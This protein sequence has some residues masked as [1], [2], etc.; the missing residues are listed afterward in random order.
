MTTIDKIAICGIRSYDPNGLVVIKFFKPLTIILGNNGCGKTTII[1][2]LKYVCTGDV[3]PLSERGRTFVHD[4]NHCGVNVVKAQVKVAFKTRDGKPVIVNSSMQLTQKPRKTEFKTIDGVVRMYDET[5]NEQIA[6]S[7]KCADMKK[8]VP[9]LMGVSRAILDNVIFCHQEEADWPLSEPKKLKEKFDEIFA[10]SRWSKA[11]TAITSYRKIL[12]TRSKDIKTD[13]KVFENNKEIAHKLTIDL[14]ETKVRM[15]QYK[16][17]SKKYSDKIS[18]FK[19]KLKPLQDARN[20]L[21]QFDGKKRVIEN[22]IQHLR[23]QQK[24]AHDR[25]KCEYEETDGELKEFLK[26]HDKQI[27]NKQ[28]ELDNVQ[29]EYTKLKKEVNNRQKKVTELHAKRGKIE[30]IKED[31]KNKK[32]NVLKRIKLLLQRYNI[33]QNKVFNGNNNNNNNNVE[34]LENNPEIMNK[35]I[36]ELQNEEKNCKKELEQ[37]QK[38]SFE[39]DK[40]LEKEISNYVTQK[41]K[42]DFRISELNKK[43]KDAINKK[44]K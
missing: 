41:N 14:Q 19:N 3:P 36:L 27:K 4:P 6:L 32:N 5:T 42:F 43:Q 16:E 13:L 25:M 12:N 37:H 30:Q 15:A 22:D 40:L 1:E 31:N 9:E 34:I 33:D 17:R 8:V 20:K 11:L 38:E 35:M 44:K 7:H 28:K 39:N 26:N 21:Q 24:N 29:I 23:Q 2:A 18:K 10:T